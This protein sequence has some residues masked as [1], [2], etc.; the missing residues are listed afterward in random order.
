MRGGWFRRHLTSRPDQS[1][2]HL[3]L[4]FPISGHHVGRD[5][6]ELDLV[7]KLR[8]QQ[9]C[10]VCLRERRVHRDTSDEYTFA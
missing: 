8:L 7:A 2:Q 4:F 5:G 3:D 10:R 9:G 1:S 6:C